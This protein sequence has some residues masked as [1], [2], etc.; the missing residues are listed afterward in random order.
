MAF[1]LA[2]FEITAAVHPVTYTNKVLLGSRQ[3]RLQLWN[4]LQNKLVHTFPGWDQEVT[5]LQQVWCDGC[6]IGVEEGVIG[7]VHL[8]FFFFFFLLRREREREDM[9]WLNPF[10][11][12]FFAKMKKGGERESE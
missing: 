1:D 11:F 8:A 12:V 10:A 3:G 4:L 7:L 2:S 5:V 6:R 9:I